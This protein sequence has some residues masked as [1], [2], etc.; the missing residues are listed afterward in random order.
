MFEYIL[1]DKFSDLS[2]FD[3]FVVYN[4]MNHPCDDNWLILLYTLNSD[5]SE[6]L[7]LNMYSNKSTGLTFAQ[8]S[9]PAFRTRES[10]N[11]QITTC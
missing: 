4:K 6:Y 9:M 3:L 8:P 2:E 1:S 5:R 11:S 10:H 7:L